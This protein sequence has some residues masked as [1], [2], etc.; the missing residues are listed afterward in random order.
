MVPQNVPQLQL[1]AA[2]A[3]ALPRTGGDAGLQ[4]LAR[5]AQAGA[6]GAAA[7]LGADQ[8]ESVDEEV[9]LRVYPFCSSGSDSR[10]FSFNWKEGRLLS[11]IARSVDGQSKSHTCHKPL[12]SPTVAGKVA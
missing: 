10:L 4:Q 8:R 7:P 9:A 12:L 11:C 3:E 1:A 2:A 6:G 5:G